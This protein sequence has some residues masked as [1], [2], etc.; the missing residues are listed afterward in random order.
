MIKEARKP[1][2]DP[3][4]EKLRQSK[5]AWNK[6]VSAF[7]NDVIHLKK[8]MNGWP[9]KYYKERSKITMPIPADPAN[10]LNSLANKFQELAQQG[11]AIAQQQAQYSQGRRK[12]RPQQAAETLNKLDEKYGPT[13]PEAA[14]LAPTTPAP[15]A[16]LTKQLGA[17]WEKKYELVAEGMDHT[18]L[19]LVA[20]RVASLARIDVP[21]DE[22]A[23][24]KYFATAVHGA[25]E[26]LMNA[27]E[28]EY[29]GLPRALMPAE[30]SKVVNMALAIGRVSKLRADRDLLEA[31]A[32]NP[33]S[34]FLARLKTPQM[35]FGA[36]AQQRRLRMDMLKA[37]IRSYRFLGKM[38]VQV[39]KSSKE[40]VGIAYKD[41]QQAW[42]E[43]SIVS[44][45]FNNYVNS[46]PDQVHRPEEMRDTP[47]PGTEPDLEGAK[48]KAP[49]QGFSQE[50]SGELQLISMSMSDTERNVSNFPDVPFV[51]ALAATIAKIKKTP[52]EKQLEAFR[53]FERTYKEALQ[54][55]NT[56]YGTNG[57]TLS[58]IADQR[59]NKTKVAT[60][61]LE[62]VAQAFLQK[63]LG[64]ARHQILPG[65]SSGLRL[66]VFELASKARKGIDAVMNS[67]E[68]GMNVDDLAPQISE[69]SGHMNTI[70]SLMRS[71]HNTER[72]PT[73]GQPTLEGFF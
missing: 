24:D 46:M 45:N 49:W 56:K 41:M 19:N 69:V 27:A 37:S 26:R 44:R 7:L 10:I 73:K 21:D 72:P 64:K 35:G 57:A 15:A 63:W 29:E 51:K 11:D 68:K 6:D 22:P 43:W 65:R 3:A 71:L 13:T 61:Q 4:Q 39:T 62:V 70:R 14:S 16:D 58:D 8:M 9:S 38:Q 47:P 53:N 34:R 32:S 25:A 5:A 18:F 12:P 40:S 59:S 17:S 31:A 66:Q 42:N 23:K 60:A 54:A 52:V 36:A 33:F 20:D 30:I 48:V 1:S 50:D 67:L 55:L 2:Q 28:A